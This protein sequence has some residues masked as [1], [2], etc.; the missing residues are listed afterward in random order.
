[1]RALRQDVHALKD[2]ILTSC[3]RLFF[4]QSRASSL[5][6]RSKNV[7][8]IELKRANNLSIALASFKIHDRYEQIIDGIITMDETAISASLLACLQRYFPT[9]QERDALQRFRGDVGTLGKPERFFYLLFQV[10][11]V[12]T[13][14]EMFLYKLEFGRMKQTLLGRI[15]VVKRACRDLAENFAFVQAIDRF[16]AKQQQRS[17]TLL[18]QNQDVFKLKFL[19]EADEK[20]ASFRGDLE[21]AANVDLTDL[22]L[23]LNRLLAG[24]RTIQS[25]VDQRRTAAVSDSS[26]SKHSSDYVEDKA[27]SGARDIFERFLLET[28]KPVTDVEDEFESM[29]QWSDKLLAVFGENKATCRLADLVECILRLL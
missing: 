1:M 27:A 10:P 11:S 6:G 23:Q 19:A 22:Q 9:E 2:R 13:R 3:A 4:C 24:R 8:L 7:S 16:F 25:F 14:I 26:A 5:R 18:D 28:R 20:L 17:V 29:E 15:L 12:Q 21:K